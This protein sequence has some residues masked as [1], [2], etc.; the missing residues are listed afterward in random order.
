MEK[1]KCVIC[2]KKH[3]LFYSIS[4]G[5]P[6]KVIEITRK[7]DDEEEQ[8]RIKKLEGN[9]YLL[10]KEYFFISGELSIETLFTENPLIHE[11]WLEFP[12]K[13][14]LS[15]IEA[16]KEKPT[17][18]LLGRTASENLLYESTLGLKAMYVLH[19]GQNVGKIEVISESQL[20]TD[21]T[22]PI[23]KERFIKMMQRIHH[24]E[25]WKEKTQFEES[26]EQRLSDILNQAENDFYDKE[27]QFVI[28]ISNNKEVLFQFIASS[29]LDIKKNG[30]IG[31]HLSND[32]INDNYKFVENKMKELCRNHM[33]E[34]FELDKIATYQ[35]GYNFDAN[36][37]F[38]DIKLLANVVFEENIESLEI[39]IFKP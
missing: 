10:D 14:Y 11:T 9:A 37:I 26:F 31:L 28:D 32:T 21:Q 7:E 2:N 38:Q 3:S 16:N 22:N 4:G 18:T 35:K 19:E 27:K 8:R 6:H 30:K 24:P 34:K 5:A 29:I 33:I 36:E 12:A 20:K 13:D 25:L 15:Q 23:T 39:S 17:L 1:Y